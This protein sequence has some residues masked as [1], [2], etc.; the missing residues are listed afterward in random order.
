L[1]RRPYGSGR[2][3][4]REKRIVKG[5]KYS[6]D[7]FNAVKKLRLERVRN[8][9]GYLDL[10]EDDLDKVPEGNDDEG[11]LKDRDDEPEDNL[12]ESNDER[13]SIMEISFNT[14]DELKIEIAEVHDMVASQQQRKMTSRNKLIRKLY[15][16]GSFSLHKIT[17]RNQYAIE[18]LRHTLYIYVPTWIVLDLEMK[19]RK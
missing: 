8:Y 19:E 7:L 17:D 14:T 4:L 18:V 6:K 1:P 3:R 2:P 10:L 15:I 11:G 16:G 12:E 13:T 5:S 9:F